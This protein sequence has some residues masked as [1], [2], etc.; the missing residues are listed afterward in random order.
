VDQVGE[1]RLR[2]GMVGSEADRSFG[3]IDAIEAIADGFDRGGAE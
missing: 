3:E 1:D 2:N